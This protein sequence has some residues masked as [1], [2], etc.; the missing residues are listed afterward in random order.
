LAAKTSPSPSDGLQDSP[1]A[2]LVT[3]PN[4]ALG[5]VAAFPGSLR[6]KA[7]RVTVEFVGKEGYKMAS[8]EERVAEVVAEQLGVGKDEITR[9]T[10]FVKDLGADSL[11]ITELVIELEEE[12]DINISDRTAKEIKTVGQAIAQIEGILENQIG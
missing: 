3:V 7:V 11:E 9:R 1:S 10:S 5:S 6:S 4:A 2:V 8:V 12:F